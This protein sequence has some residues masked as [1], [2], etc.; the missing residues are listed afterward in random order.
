MLLVAKAWTE[1]PGVVHW[2]VVVPWPTTISGKSPR[3]LAGRMS[4]TPIV[5]MPGSGE[6]GSNCTL[7]RPAPSV[8]AISSVLRRA[9]K[10]AGGPSNTVY[11]TR[12]PGSGWPSERVTTVVNVTPRPAPARATAQG[13]KRQAAS[14]QKIVAVALRR[15]QLCSFGAQTTTWLVP[16]V[17]DVTVIQ[18]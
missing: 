7:A 4:C 11:R 13:G 15:S 10:K 3:P 9:E 2:T 5:V 6:P 18:A 12:Q 1:R 17:G 14:I 16:S 8:I